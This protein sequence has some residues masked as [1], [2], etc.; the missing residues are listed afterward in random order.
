MIMRLLDQA[1]A[2]GELAEEINTEALTEMVFAG[3]MGASVIYGTEK[4][5]VCLD[6]SINAL[7][8][9]LDRLAPK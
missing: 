2:S 3:M 5:T 6:R 9:S 1:K 4:S 8:E 7:M